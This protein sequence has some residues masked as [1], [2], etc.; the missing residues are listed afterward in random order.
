ML[1]SD[2]NEASALPSSISTR[3]RPMKKCARRLVAIEL[4]SFIAVAMPHG[5]FGLPRF[6][7]DAHLVQVHV[8]R[9]EVD[10]VHGGGVPGTADVLAGL[11]DVAGGRA[12]V[13]R[14][15]GEH[16]AAEDCVEI[17]VREG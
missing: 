10:P 3:A 9:R 2:F 4:G 16:G 13:V 8:R 1:H 17:T 7:G 6:R 15:R 14:S 12:P 5:L 11:L